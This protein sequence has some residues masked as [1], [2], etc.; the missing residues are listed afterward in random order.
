MAGLLRGDFVQVASSG[1]IP[2]ATILKSGVR[3]RSDVDALAARSDY[4]I[5]VLVWNYRDENTGSAARIDL[6]ING[7]PQETNRLLLRHYRID[8]NHS[9]AYT[10]WRQMG[11]PQ[12]PNPA[13]Y[14]KLE[15]AG[16]LQL[17]RSPRWIGERA[18]SVEVEFS[19]PLE[20]LSLVQLSW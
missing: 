20:S 4:G 3:G 13:Q 11:S 18:G 10:V 14:K 1:A 17:F 16:Q 7:L 6:R 8:R 12:S 9:N 2:V 19:L 15:S 5:S